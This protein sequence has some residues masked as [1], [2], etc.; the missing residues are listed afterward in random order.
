MAGLLRDKTR[1][2]G[3]PPLAPETVRRVV[4]L[5]CGQAPGEATH[6]S[7]RMM[8]KT[9]GISLSSVQTKPKLAPPPDHAVTQNRAYLYKRFEIGCKCT[10]LCAWHRMS[11]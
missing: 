6:W 3:K 8:A 4:T 2:P 9:V 5:T 10:M 1:P 11:A 7:G